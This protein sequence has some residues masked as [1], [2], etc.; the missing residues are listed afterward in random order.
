M[1]HIKRDKRSEQSCQW[2][3]NALAQCMREKDYDEISVVE[4]VMKAGV[5]R[6]T[7]YRNFDGIDDVL[8]LECDRAFDALRVQFVD[9]YKSVENTDA[10][11]VFIKPLLRYW[12]A[13]TDVIERLIR[14][15][16]TDLIN[17][18]IARLI[19]FVLS[20]RMDPDEQ[21]W[22]RLDYF[23]AKRAGEAVNVL[24]HWVKNHKDIPADEL[25]DLIT[26]QSQESVNLTLRL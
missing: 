16:R 18:G 25:A 9:H 24:I 6:A 21:A 20:S 7:F 10:K 12:D 11:T 22:H 13:R 23:I 1:Y 2:I 14:A 15:N 5:G 19:E 3:I 4:L 26:L 8:R 17:D